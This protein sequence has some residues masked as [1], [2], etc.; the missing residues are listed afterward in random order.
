MPVLQFAAPAFLFRWSQ[1]FYLPPPAWRM[2]KDLAF[3]LQ[4]ELLSLRNFL[5]VTLLEPR[6]SASCLENNGFLQKQIR[7]TNPS[8]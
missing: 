2:A 4:L 3:F 1:E 5:G 6:F 7:L 8:R